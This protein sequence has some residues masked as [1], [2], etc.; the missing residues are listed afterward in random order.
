MDFFTALSV[1]AASTGTI[2]LGAALLFLLGFRGLPKSLLLGASY[3]AGVVIAAKLLHLASFLGLALSTASWIAVAI[4][5]I[6]GAWTWRGMMAQRPSTAHTAASLSDPSMRALG[7]SWLKDPLIIIL[8]SLLAI[9]I[10]IT[11]FNNLTRP[12]FPWDAFTTWM[13]R[14]KAWTLQNA[15]STMSYAPDWIAVGGPS[16]FAIYAN[17]YPT[18][19]SI[20]AAFMAALTGGWNEAAASV[21][22]SLALIAACCVIHG[23]IVAAGLKQRMAVLGAYFLGSL[24][25]VNIHASL[26]GY[27]DLWML[28]LSGS[29]L[30]L[31]LLWRCVGEQKFMLIAATLLVA[32]TQI[33]TEGWLWLLLGGIFVA[34]ESLAGRFGYGKLLAAIGAG[35]SLIWL[36]DLTTLSLG[37]LGSWGVDQNGIQIGALGS[38]ALRPYNPLGDYFRGIFLQANFLVL[39]TMYLSSVIA[40]ATSKAD[41]AAAFWLMGGLIA[42]SQG[43]IFGLSAF[44][45]YAE[46]GTAITRILIHFL[47]VATLTC[48]MGWAAVKPYV[49]LSEARDNTNTAS[50]NAR[51]LKTYGLALTI[52]L[53]ALASPVLFV[54]DASQHQAN[55]G[56]NHNQL[57]PVAGRVMT[58]P[59]GL[60][61]VDSPISV[62]V[63]SAPLTKDGQALPNYL[64]TDTS[65]EYAGDVSF[66]WI[67]K[68]GAEVHSVPLTVNGYSI[69][70]LGKVEAWHKQPFQ[71]I[72]F[73]VRERAFKSSLIRGFELKQ[74]LDRSD[75]TE[76]L[77]HWTSTEPLS[78]KLINSTKGHA[79]APISLATWANAAALAVALIMLALLFAPATKNPLSILGVALLIIWLSVDLASV[80]S[81][82]ARQT[83]KSDPGW[84]LSFPTA[85]E[86]ELVTIIQ[87]PELTA[88]E[89]ERVLIVTDRGSSQLLAQKLPY[90]LLPVR[91]VFSDAQA[92]SERTIRSAGTIVLLNEDKQRMRTLIESYLSVRP[93]LKLTLLDGAA[94]LSTETR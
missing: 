19:L 88:S 78:H 45:Q 31:L 52:A 65:F 80:N 36:F 14:G 17:D 67:P 20:Y 56:F 34:A 73:L 76:L 40:L 64:K 37:P 21:P 10:S 68:D 85:L 49:G 70:D 71:E 29:G 84:A 72:G 58:S 4:G 41:R 12:I 77:N 53:V 83:K 74:S 1:L 24:P 63:L 54:L 15:I 22:W 44:S 5:L 33:K 90:A 60:R 27:A 38:Y 51:P 32:G 94:I 55:A 35:F 6:A 75:A 50:Q 79:D 92:V 91:A 2:G 87:S 81:S 66:Y 3:G 18:A 25:I 46:I 13:Y 48:I 30:A 11:L 82:A 16:D 59:N 57:Q 86:V 8:L 23:S 39:G 9:H 28:L 26:A 43:M 62:G 93:E 89:R 42:T 47:P 7:Y 69:T 61:F